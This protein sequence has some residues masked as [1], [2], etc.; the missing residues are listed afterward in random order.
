MRGGRNGAH[1]PRALQRVLVEP[2]IDIVFAIIHR[3]AMVPG[4]V[5]YAPCEFTHFTHC[6]NF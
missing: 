6:V 1:G 3:L 2:G 5:R 4:F